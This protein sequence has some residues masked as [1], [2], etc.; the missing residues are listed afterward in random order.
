MRMHGACSTGGYASPEQKKRATCA[1][2]CRVASLSIRLQF[3]SVLR[4]VR[5]TSVELC[6]KHTQNLYSA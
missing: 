4:N 5:L 2:T 1:K 3:L 6:K